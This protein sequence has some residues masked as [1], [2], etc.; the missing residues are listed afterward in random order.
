MLKQNSNSLEG[1]EL[2]AKSINDFGRHFS[3]A[4][5]AKI[6]A[7][8]YARVPQPMAQ[9]VLKIEKLSH[10][11]GPTPIL[12]VARAYGL[13]PWLW[14]LLLHVSCWLARRSVLRKPVPE[15]SCTAQ[16]RRPRAILNTKSTVFPNTYR[17]RPANNIFVFSLQ[18]Y[19]ESNSCVEFQF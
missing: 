11:M 15:V 18:Y 1:G 9:F 5:S 19:F 3:C 14:L 16:G 8:K 4:T 10:I 2:W 12:E 6:L 13:R 17:P 7:A